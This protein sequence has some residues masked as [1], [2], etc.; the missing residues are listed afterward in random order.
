M[1]QTDCT[2]NHPPLLLHVFS[3]F[4]VGGT[5]MRFAALAAAFG[6][7]YRHVIMA[8]DGNCGAAAL[9]PR[10]LLVSCEPAR[11]DTTFGNVCRFRR[12]LRE[13]APDVLVTYNW[14]AIEWA[15]ANIPRIVPHIHVEDGFGPEERARQLRRRVLARRLLLARSMVVVP[16]RTLWRI[17]T[18][19]W[20]LDPRLV[21]HIPNGIDLGRFAGE[22]ERRAVPVIGTVAALRSEKNL[23]RLLHA[24]RIVAHAMPARLLIVGDGPEREKLERLAVELELG[25]RVHFFGHVDEPAALYRQMDV[26]V[27]SSDTEQMPLSVIEAMVSGLP[28]AATDVGDVATMVAAEN[29]AFITDP[30]EAALARSIAALAGDTGLRTRL[31]AANRMKA[32]AEFGQARMIAAWRA[33]FEAEACGPPARCMQPHRNA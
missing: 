30:E 5:Q 22:R 9:I 7:R 32:T 21:R 31:G 18:E 2:V 26:F 27:L 8:T 20:R 6:P 24:F 15:M 23:A 28:I 33:I 25:G 13:L 19:V 17:A 14:G 1:V 29:R 3:S 12:R 10:S 16:S 11:A 4:S